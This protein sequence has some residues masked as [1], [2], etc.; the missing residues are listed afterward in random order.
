MS[1][2]AYLLLTAAATAFVL[3]L[4]GGVATYALR[5]GSVSSLKV[6][7]SVPADVVNAR[8]AEYRRLIDEANARLRAREP[9]P[10]AVPIRTAPIA[11]RR[12]TS[13]REEEDRLHGESHRGRQH[14]EDDD[15]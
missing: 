2:R 3:V 7:D 14:R 13:E 6:S 8:E 9:G 5:S 10:A 12:S 15:G 1:R 11:A 4:T